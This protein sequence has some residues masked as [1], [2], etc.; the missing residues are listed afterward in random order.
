MLLNNLNNDQGFRNFYMNKRGPII[1][2]L[3]FDDDVIL[4]SSGNRKSLK[5]IMRTLKTYED[6][7][8]QLVN[9]HKSSVILHDKACARRIDRAKRI[10]T[11]KQECF[12]INYL[13]CPLYLG[14][15]R[16]STFSVTVQKILNKIRGWFFKF[17]S[18]G[19]KSVLIKHVLQAMPSHLLAVMQPPKTVFEIIENAFNRFLWSGS[20]GN[21]KLHWSSWDNLSYPIN[22][23]GANFRKLADISKAFT[24]K[25]W[26]K[27][28][29]KRYLWSLFLNTK[30]CSRIH[31]VTNKWRNGQSHNWKAMCSIK[32]L[33]E[34][35]L[36][37]II[38]KGEV[39]FWYDNWTD[40]GP[41]YKFLDP[42]SKPSKLR[43]TDAYQ[44]G[45]WNWP[46]C[47]YVV[48]DFIKAHIERMQV[49][50]SDKPDLPIWKITSSGKF[51]IESAWNFLRNSRHESNIVNALCHKAVPFKMS[52]MAWRVFH[53]KIP[54]N[55]IIIS[56]F[57]LLASPNCT[58][59]RVSQPENI[60]HIFFQS[61]VA[62]S[63]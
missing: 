55:D 21:K 44:N 52:F 49:V 50:L 16:I 19:G 33:V 54:S 9:K 17:L 46:A 47:G 43:I 18:V 5:R 13:G 48:S 39:A 53:R 61:Y 14:R 3:C 32:V 35:N 28:R 45:H 8:G 60:D 27:L 1:N 15:K 10:T 51:N 37:W 58:C 31:P 40:L 26:W 29:T 12:P 36:G 56:W 41:L 38:E 20:D 59:C 4:F 42:D 22:D 34:N 6:V 63:A 11:M 25:H 30:Y 24:T 2:H 62:S 23:G 57:K 7:S